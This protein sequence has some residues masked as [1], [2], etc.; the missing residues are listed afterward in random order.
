MEIL[1]K[2]LHVIPT[3][4]PRFG[5][6]TVACLELCEAIAAIGV[7][8]SI[9]TTTIEVPHWGNP[10]GG[11]VNYHGVEVSFFPKV[12]FDYYWFSWGLYTALRDRLPEF[13]V[14]HVH[15]LYR[16]HLPICMHFASKYGIPMV[17]KPH[18][19]LDPFLFVRRRWR[20]V[21]HEWF[22]ERP[23][24]RN[25]AALHFTSEEE[26][27]LAISTGIFRGAGGTAKVI[28]PSGVVVA[29]GITPIGKPS[30]R[31]Q[32]DYPQLEGKK[33]ILF[34]GRINFKKGLD[35]LVKAFGLLAR[36][37]P[38]VHLLI[39]GPDNEG[40]G[41]KVKDWI[42]QEN[43]R[44]R[45]TVIDML[46][47][48]A[49]AAAYASADVFVLSSYT[50]NFGLTV[51]EAMSVGLPVVVSDRVNIWREVDEA[52]A[53]LVVPCDALQTSNAIRRILDDRTAAAEM[54]VRGKQL[55]NDKFTWPSI[56]VLM[57]NI[58]ENL[59]ERRA[60]HGQQ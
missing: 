39:V 43:V 41:K 31:L 40:Y 15:S 32:Q 57:R 60:G 28:V 6:S 49:K 5:G 36:I 3:L 30:Y 13:D 34:L 38:A 21:A 47:G 7:N 22:F 37:D 24:F 4:G 48:E 9:Y 26:K 42:E 16:S 53:G 52:Q 29:E 55:V 51:V 20:K 1:L 10:R 8:T 18:G 46:T 54:G 56:A 58:Y 12:G 50:E 25:A 11:I 44:D 19:S 27:V 45:T 2:V 14:L 33:V 17:V 59:V 23:A 35:I